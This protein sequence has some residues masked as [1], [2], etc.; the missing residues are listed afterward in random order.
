MRIRSI[1]NANPYE[2]IKP[3]VMRIKNLI[4]LQYMG[5]IPYILMIEY[6]YAI[7]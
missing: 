3:L 6:D 7:G 5:L 2:F 1:S 4:C